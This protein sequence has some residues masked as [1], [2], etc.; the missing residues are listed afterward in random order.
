[1]SD[2]IIGGEEKNKT[3]IELFNEYLN[4]NEKSFN[5]IVRIHRKSLISFVN[6]YVRDLEVA[7]DIVQDTFI[8]LLM[9]KHA[10]NPKYS[11]KSYLF[12]I[13]KSRAINYLK[14]QKRVNNYYEDNIQ[15][16]KCEISLDEELIKEEK[17]KEI[18]FALK[19]IKKEYQIAIFLKDLQEFEYDEVSRILNKTLPQTRLLIHRARKSLLKILR[20]EEE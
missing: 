19:E 8:Y 10:Y 18:Y 5:E 2:V 14:K 1:M 16:I 13:A 7:E 6:K 3:D 11:L 17:K 9:N 4:G 15:N 12:I 20:K